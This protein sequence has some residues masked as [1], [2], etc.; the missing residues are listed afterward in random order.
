M[1]E[2]IDGEIGQPDQPWMEE[3]GEGIEYYCG[4]DVVLAMDPFAYFLVQL[5]KF[6]KKSH[7]IINSWPHQGIWEDLF[8][9]VC[10]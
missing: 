8:G 3:C 2:E 5:V 10:L 7:F 9:R 4:K 1:R 6:M